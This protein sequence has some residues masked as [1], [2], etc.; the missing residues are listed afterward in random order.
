MFDLLHFAK[1]DI[2]IDLTRRCCGEDYDYA[3]RGRELPEP[4][5]FR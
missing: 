1:V 5:A 4:E 2:K 3:D